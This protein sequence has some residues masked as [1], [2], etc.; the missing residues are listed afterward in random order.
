AVRRLN[1]ALTWTLRMSAMRLYASRPAFLELVID[2]P[3]TYSAAE[4]RETLLAYVQQ[5][6]TALRAATTGPTPTPREVAAQ[7]EKNIERLRTAVEAIA[8]A[9]TRERATL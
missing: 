5:G 7:W 9:G 4:A 1:P 6:E 3:R 2:E 8:H